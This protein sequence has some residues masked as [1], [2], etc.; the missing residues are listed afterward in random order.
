MNVQLDIAGQSCFFDLFNSIS[1]WTSNHTSQ[2]PHWKGTHMCSVGVLSQNAAISVHKALHN[3]PTVVP[4]T[5]LTVHLEPIG[6]ANEQYF[7]PCSHDTL[8]VTRRA[9][10]LAMLTAPAMTL[11]PGFLTALCIRTRWRNSATAGH[12]RAC[13]SIQ[14]MEWILNHSVTHLLVDLPSLDLEQDNTKCGLQQARAAM[15]GLSPAQAAAAPV[16]RE[17]ARNTFTCA[18]SIPDEVKDGIFL[19]S[20]AAGG[21]DGYC[22]PSAPALHR[23]VGPDGTSDLTPRVV[24]ADME[25][26]LQQSLQNSSWTT[27]TSHQAARSEAHLHSSY[28]NSSLASR[29]VANSSEPYRYGHRDDSSESYRHNGNSSEPYRHNDNSSEPG[30]AATPRDLLAEHST[31]A[32]MLQL[33]QRK[34]AFERFATSEQP[35]EQPQEI[36]VATTDRFVADSELDYEPEEQYSDEL[37]SPLDAAGW[38]GLDPASSEQFTAD[39]DLE[40]DSRDLEQ[41]SRDLEQDDLQPG[42]PPSVPPSIHQ[43]QSL[44]EKSRAQI[45][46]WQNSPTYARIQQLRKREVLTSQRVAAVAAQ[47]MKA[48]NRLA[49]NNTLSVTE[50]GT[51]LQGTEHEPFAGWMLEQRQRRFKQFS[52]DGGLTISELREAVAAYQSQRGEQGLFD[53]VK[54]R[55]QVSAGASPVASHDW[56]NVSAAASSPA[57]RIRSHMAKQVT[58]QDQHERDIQLNSMNSR[59]DRDMEIM[60]YTAS[61]M[62]EAS[63]ANFEQEPLS[64]GHYQPELLS[65]VTGWK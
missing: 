53:E 51:F 25:S 38:R 35:P 65:S 61:R 16:N 10:E 26:L 24:G 43:L 36:G 48:A 12:V 13:F 34:A 30:T 5:V 50:L 22:M 23:I 2:P 41:D 18:A 14:A 44:R 58:F 15:F 39:R 19:L 28:H 37:E 3:R 63:I 27:G 64:T 59:T 32:A 57:S 4:C 47:I 46:S 8:C 52:K 42:T 11:R 6:A 49:K 9:L 33:A 1:I 45:S 56:N 40:Q 7:A 20:L 54:T 17:C 55:N 21:F 29:H 62:N 31:E 60:N